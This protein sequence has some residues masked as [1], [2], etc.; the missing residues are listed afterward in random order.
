M[1]LFLNPYVLSPYSFPY[2]LTRYV[3]IVGPTLIGRGGSGSSSACD[4][5]GNVC[6]AREFSIASWLGSS[7][8]IISSDD[9]CCCSVIGLKIFPKSSCI[10]CSPNRSERKSFWIMSLALIYS[11]TSAS[12]LLWS[13]TFKK[14]VYCM[15]IFW[16][17]LWKFL[18]M[19]W[20]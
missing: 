9:F 19:F 4:P 5:K 8:E 14:L 11:A 17:M 16:G 3:P 1:P 12:L 10:D 20:M 6:I 15:F 18:D 13:L 7:L 2:D